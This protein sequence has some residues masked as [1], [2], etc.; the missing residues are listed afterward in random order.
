MNYRELQQ[1]LSEMSEQELDQTVTA[2]LNFEDEFIAVTS[3]LV[4]EESDV[5][6]KGHIYLS[7]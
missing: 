6:D 7:V 1:I 2:Y 5:L 3:V 4:A